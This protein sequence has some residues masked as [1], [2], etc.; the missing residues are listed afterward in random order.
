MRYNREYQTL[1]DC[2]NAIV[3]FSTRF[4]AAEASRSHVRDIIGTFPHIPA[5]VTLELIAM[6]TILDR[7]ESLIFVPMLSNL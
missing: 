1:A 6:H 4:W 3:G 7:G 5:P 2:A